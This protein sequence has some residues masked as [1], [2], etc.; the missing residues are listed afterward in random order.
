M[1]DPGA[2]RSSQTAYG[3]PIRK[4][5]FTIKRS[6]ENLGERVDFVPERNVDRWGFKGIAPIVAKGNC[7]GLSAREG[8][9]LSS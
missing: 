7:R 8:V 5:P 4:K 6:R 9:P 3:M 1:E 2:T